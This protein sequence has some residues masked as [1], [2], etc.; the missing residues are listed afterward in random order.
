M[1][2]ALPLLVLAVLACRSDEKDGSSPPVVDSDTPPDS[3]PETDAPAD[4]GWEYETVAI[5]APGRHVA[6]V[7]IAGYGDHNWLVWA[8]STYTSS[9]GRTVLLTAVGDSRSVTEFGWRV[10]TDSSPNPSIA[11]EPDSRSVFVGGLATCDPAWE[12]ACPA[13]PQGRL[14]EVLVVDKATG[15]WRSEPV[16]TTWPTLD[17]GRGD[18]A[19]RDGQVDACFKAEHPGLTDDELTCNHRD[20]AGQ[21]G[22][23]VTLTAMREGADDHAT[24][25]LRADQTRIAGYVT[26]VGGIDRRAAVALGAADGSASHRVFYDAGAFLKG[27]DTTVAQDAAGRIHAVWLEL[28]PGMR[29]Q[30]QHA[31]CDLDDGGAGCSPVEAWTVTSLA[32][33]VV[34]ASPDITTHGTMPIATWTLDGRV[35]IG[36]S[37]DDASFTVEDVDPSPGDQST[38]RGQP[39]LR[40]DAGDDLLHVVYTQATDAG[41][42]V[43]WAR[44]PLPSCP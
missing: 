12:I 43:R 28:V 15:A 26:S 23:A 31:R 7:G 3:D 25:V 4:P 24:V 30:V 2:R 8:D 33:G 5:G 38:N 13:D 14:F 36:W 9:D 21:W 19:M 37:C 1:S 18:I 20:A 39:S 10:R 16:D 22:T 17:H 27:D 6:D 34:V 11:T 29:L 35:Q 32:E 42:E 44:R 41:L 40:V